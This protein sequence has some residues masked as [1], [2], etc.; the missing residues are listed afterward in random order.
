MVGDGGL[1]IDALVGTSR[2]VVVH[3]LKQDA[4]QMSSIEDE[5]EIQAFFSG[6]A[7][8]AFR[9]CVGV[10]SLER[11]IDDM[12]AFRLEDCIK[13]QAERA[14]VIMDQEPKRCI[15][16][17]KFPDQLPG[18]LSNPEL[19][20]IG[21]DSGKVNTARAQF[22]EE[23]H[24]DGLKQDSFH[25]EEITRQ[26]LLFV[27]IHQMSPAKRAMA[28]R[29][30]LDAV[31]VENVANGW[32][33]NLEIQL[34]DFALDFAVTP[35]RVFSGETENKVFDFLAGR[36]SLVV[37]LCFC[38]GRSIFDE[39]IRDANEEWFQVGRCG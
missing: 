15:S 25:G 3:E 19:I 6:S 17:G 9:E 12:K 4:P 39:L 2:V 33:G 16:I 28:N 8:P 20:G 34:D 14:I 10:G 13:G 24:V 18:L 29:S 37:H 21:D 1:L 27:V 7:D 11:N 36:W 31:T 32:L 38:W 30:W 23:E 26:D 35:A 5:N 22:D